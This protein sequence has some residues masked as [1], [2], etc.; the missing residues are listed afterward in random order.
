MKTVHLN[1]NQ[2]LYTVETKGHLYPY[3]GI[4]A[5]N[6]TNLYINNFVTGNH[7]S[8]H[9]NHKPMLKHLRGD[10]KDLYE[11][12]V[13]DW[14]GDNFYEPL[15]SWGVA[16]NLFSE[17][18]MRPITEEQA[19]LFAEAN[20]RFLVR[21]ILDEYIAAGWTG[22][23][24]PTAVEFTPD[25]LKTTREKYLPKLSDKEEILAHYCHKKCVILSLYDAAMLPFSRKVGVC[26]KIDLK[27]SGSGPHQVL[28]KAFPKKGENSIAELKGEWIK[29]KEP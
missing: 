3:F 10:K 8:I 4:N 12:E 24:I 25:K 2:L 14:S 26:H 1:D 9:A 23:V 17:Q 15:G 13:E 18:H 11:I 7:L 27:T 20:K 29:F 6:K 16:I 19:T 22:V 5:P 28:V 21:M